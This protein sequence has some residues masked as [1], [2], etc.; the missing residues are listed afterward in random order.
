[1]TRHKKIWLIAVIGVLGV[2]IIAGAVAGGGLYQ[3]LTN[4]YNPV[5]SNPPSIIRTPE[6]DSQNQTEQGKIADALRATVLHSLRT[7]SSL[8]LLQPSLT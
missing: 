6:P 3:R 2:L 7:V 1:M 8:L 5:R 4:S